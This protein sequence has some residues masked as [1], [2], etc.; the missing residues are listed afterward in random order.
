[1]KTKTAALISASVAS[2]AI[3]GGGHPARIG[4]LE[5]YGR[6]IGLAFQIIDDILDIEGDPDHLGKPVGSDLARGKATYPTAVG[7]R[8]AREKAG[9]LVGE[10]LDA[11]LPFEEKAEPLREIARYL[12]TRKK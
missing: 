8:A 1:M 9:S 12:L 4:N 6:K 7:L 5:R 3:L 2:G 11:L 10:A